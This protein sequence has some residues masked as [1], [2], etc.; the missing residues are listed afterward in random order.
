VDIVWEAR[1]LNAKAGAPRK[2]VRAT[3]TA[4]RGD[5]ARF[6]EVALRAVKDPDR[7]FDGQLM[8]VLTEEGWLICAGHLE[9][10]TMVLFDGARRLAVTC[11]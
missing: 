9:D 11:S 5:L 10:G 3:V 6:Q 7:P 1:V 8:S 2:G 4:L